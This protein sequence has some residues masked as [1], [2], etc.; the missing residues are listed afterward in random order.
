MPQTQNSCRPPHPQHHLVFH[1]THR[2]ILPSLLALRG[3]R[4]RAPQLCLHAGTPVVVIAVDVDVVV[5]VVVGAGRAV[6]RRTG[7]SSVAVAASGSVGVRPSPT[8]QV[9]ARKPSLKLGI[10]VAVAVAVAAVPR[11]WTSRRGGGGIRAAG[12]VPD[13]VAAGRFRYGLGT[14][15][16]LRWLVH[17]YIEL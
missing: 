16:P 7:G 1:P 3:R 2:R 14:T 12:D 9:S 8:T 4:G 5:A 17:R 13:L 6:A 15:K 10:L 11:R